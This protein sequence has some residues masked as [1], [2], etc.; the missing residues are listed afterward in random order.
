MPGMVSPGVLKAAPKDRLTAR[1]PGGRSSS[2]QGFGKL[3]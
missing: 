1:W 2:D 3:D